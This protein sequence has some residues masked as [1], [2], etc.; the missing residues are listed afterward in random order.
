MKRAALFL[1][2]VGCASAEPPRRETVP[3]PGSMIPFDLVRVP[4]RGPIRDFWMGAREVTWEEFDRFT[5]FPREE[6]LDGVTRPSRGKDYVML[7]GLPSE[8]VQPKRPVTNL[9]WHAAIAYCEWLSKKTGA[10]YRL[11]TEPE[12]DL[13]CGDVTPDAGWT[14]ADSGERTHVG[15]EKPAHASG[16]WDLTGNVWEYALEPAIPPVFEPVLLGGAWNEPSTA[17]QTAPVDWAAA[18]PNR[19]LS[20]WWYRAGHSQGFR[21]VR[22]GEASDRAA[23]EAYEDRIEIRLLKSEEHTV[24][25]GTSVS[26]FMRVT[27]SIRNSGDRVLDEV[28]LK[29]YYLGADGKPHVEDKTLTFTRRA[30]FNL[31]MP[32]LAGSAYPGAHAGALLPGESRD[33]AVD[34]PVSFEVDEPRFGASVWSLRWTN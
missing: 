3:I 26:L 10:L 25:A 29:V 23:R 9:R 5:E 33:F 34:V 15:G 4:G 32:V 22:V 7:S 11:P 17:R 8:F 30:T 13:A 16:V 24:R 14:K 19:P 12:W 6:E 20:S 31:A 1:A 18:D 27:G 2:L 28:L 21:V